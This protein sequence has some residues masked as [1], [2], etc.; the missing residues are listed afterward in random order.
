MMIFANILR[1]VMTGRKPYRNNLEWLRVLATGMDAATGSDSLSSPPSSAYASI[2]SEWNAGM[3]SG[4]WLGAL[5]E[6]T[7]AS[8]H[9]SAGSSATSCCRRRRVR[10]SGA[11]VLGCWGAGVLGCWGA[12]VLAC[13]VQKV[14]GC[15]TG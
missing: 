2:G 12:G 13:W 10:V 11:R 6:F 8:L 1:W 15:K 7:R 9:A 5:A 4:V 3:G 14:A